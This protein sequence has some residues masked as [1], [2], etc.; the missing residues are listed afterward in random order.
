MTHPRIDELPER[1]RHPRHLWIFD[2]P[3]LE[4]RI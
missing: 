3:E 1:Y 2:L 4:T